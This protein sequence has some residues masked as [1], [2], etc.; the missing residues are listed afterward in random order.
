LKPF[1]AQVEPKQLQNVLFIV[2][3]E[4]LGNCHETSTDRL[5]CSSY[6]CSTH[7]RIP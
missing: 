5:P 7:V 3:N 6:P 4:K 1:T 2:H